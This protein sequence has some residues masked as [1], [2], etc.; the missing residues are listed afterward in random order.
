M[1]EDETQKSRVT[2]S[3][4][5][6]ISL[7]WIISEAKKICK[8]LELPYTRPPTCPNVTVFRNIGSTRKLT[9]TIVVTHPAILLELHQ[10]SH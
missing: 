6:G 8:T 9:D 5:I 7:F 2:E 1:S 10:F 3:T 4:G